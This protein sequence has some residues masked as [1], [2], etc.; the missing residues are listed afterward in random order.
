[1]DTRTCLSR[2]ARRRAW[3]GHAAAGAAISLALAA[4]AGPA[5]AADPPVA[6]TIDLARTTQ[7]GTIAGGVDERF[8]GRPGSRRAGQAVALPGDLNGDGRQD[9]AIGMPWTGR[10]GMVALVYGEPTTGRTTFVPPFGARGVRIYGPIGS[11]AGW[12][13]AG[14]GDLNG[15]GIDDLL[16][17]APGAAAAGRGRPGAVYVV[18]GGPRLR[19]RRI[20]L[21]RPGAGV[22]ISGAA[23]ADN[24]GIAVASIDDLDRDGARDV[25][26]GAPDADGLGRPDAGSAFVVHSSALETDVDLASL[27]T[28]GFRID[29]AAPGDDAARAVAG[30]GDM[31]GDGLGEAVI[32]APAASS[33]S[34][35]VHVVFGRAPGAA[36]IDLANLGGDGF[37]AFGSGGERA[38]HSVAG[39]GDATGDG[40]P[41]VAVGA[42]RSSWNGRSSSGAAYVM[43][44]RA[45]SATSVLPAGGLRVGGGDPFDYLGTA[46]AAAGDVD[47]NGRADALIG[48]IGTDALWRR[49]A[50]EALVLLMGR[51]PASGDLDAALL[52]HTAMRLAGPVPGSVAGRSL[53]GGVRVDDDERPDVLVGLPDRNSEL[54]G[55]NLVLLPAAPGVPVAPP[56]T[57]G[58]LATN[59][60]VV[61]DDTRSMRRFD[62]TNALRRGAL[63]RMLVDPAAQDRVLSA[64][65]FG[66]RAH[67]IF[68]PISI[69]E[70]AIAGDR[71]NVLEALL[72]ERIAGNAAGVS[73]VPA[74]LSA[75]AAANPAAHARIL[76]TDSDDPGDLG[77]FAGVRTDVIGIGAATRGGRRNLEALARESGGEFYPVADGGQLQSALA[78]IDA[79]LRGE[80]ALD[81]QVKESPG[82]TVVP[83]AVPGEAAVAVTRPRVTV[84][85]AVTAAPAKARRL[86]RARLVTTW[87]RRV[88]RVRLKT[89]RFRL[90]SARVRAGRKQIRRALAGRWQPL[91][92]G[93]SIRGRKGR[94]FVVLNVRGLAKAVPGRAQ[95]AAGSIGV[96]VGVRCTRCRGTRLRSSWTYQ[97]RPT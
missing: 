31:N 72:A 95:A 91:R 58:S 88:S 71:L 41:D 59:V 27:G 65:E 54:G 60:A 61:I 57:G 44:G 7:P 38:G 40:R 4:G 90:G 49:S 14:G 5:R 97:R 22:R 51:A 20:M 18:F 11:Y 81:T 12:S 74:G 1:M 30:V 85:F 87:N 19:L 8:I 83:P 68:P 47:G 55:A 35:A 36:P 53:A 32:G 63:G 37:T 24:T 67:Q 50:G 56:R 23:H 17:G 26:V 64:V 80:P 86:Q 77:A 94:T 73:D 93:L 25:L 13:V 48:V 45:D 10:G 76:L 89:L 2:L 52:G 6:G 46:V 43:P 39:L 92:R 82:V 75:A 9:Y 79:R 84:A 33:D 70:S 78:A 21:G 28:G 69:G 66:A 16:I 42:P 96:D 34:G 3:N 62:P 15:D 29:G